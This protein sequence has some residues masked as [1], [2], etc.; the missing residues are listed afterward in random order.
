MFINQFGNVIIVMRIFQTF[1]LPD[2]LVA[3]HN[4][5]FAAANFSR[6]LISGGGFDRIFSLIPVNVM[7]DVGLHAED[8]YELVYSSW[9]KKGKFLSKLAI[10][11]EQCSVFRQIYKG[12]SIWMYNL[13]VMNVLLFI[14]LKVFKPSV[15]LNVI[16]LDFT[17]AKSWKEQNYWYLKLLNSADGTICLAHSHLFKCHNTAVL[18]GVVPTSAGHEPLIECP[19]KK[20]LLSGVLNEEIAQ[21]STLLG[22]FSQLPTCELHI[23]GK[24][25]NVG[26]IQKYA[27]KY[28]NIIWHGVISFDSYLNLMHECTFVLSTRDSDSPENQCNFPSKIIESLLHNRIVISTIT[29]K[30]LDGLRYFICTNKM[31]FMIDNIRT[32]SYLP[33]NTLMDY[34]NQG[35]KV[36]EMFSTNMWNKTMA[37][38]EKEE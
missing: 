14:L 26:Q 35:R 10:F 17:P 37:Q 38:I 22:V 6:N 12:D 36:I 29:Y 16:I 18:P 31:P 28:S 3:K 4:L 7:G 1:I 11:K 32:I 13:N 19:N 25:D 9:R 15:K 23:T 24:S 8:G 33:D 34:A 2:D 30:Q 5:S 20:F 27:D 21:I